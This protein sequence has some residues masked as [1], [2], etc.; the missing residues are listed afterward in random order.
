M[1]RSDGW[2]AGK[3]RAQRGR[4]RRARTAIGALALLLL[5]GAGAEAATRS[6][7]LRWSPS[8][9]SEVAGYRVY[10]RTLSGTW[11]TPQDVGLPAP[12]SD[13]TL[14]ATVSG[15]DT[16]VSYAFAVAAYGTSGVQGSLSNEL[17]L[18]AEPA[19]TTTTVAPSPS[20]TTTTQPPATT[21]TVVQQTTTTSSTSTSTTLPPSSGLVAAYAFSEGAGTTAADVSGHGNHGTVSGAAWAAGRMGAALAFD[22]VDDAVI[23]PDRASLDLTA[24]LTLEAWISPSVLSGWRV[25]VDKTTTGLPSNYYLGLYG[26]EVAFGFYAGGAWR[27]HVTS[28]VDLPANAWTH[29]AATFDDAADRVRIYVNGVLRLSA[30]ELGRPV[31]NAEQLRIGIGFANEAFAGRIDEVRVYDRA[32]T[33]SQIQADMNAAADA[34]SLASAALLPE[35]VC[36]SG[37]P[38]RGAKLLLK[39]TRLVARAAFDSLAPFDPSTA[40]M[41]LELADRDGTVLLREELPAARFRAG[42]GG[43]VFKHAGEPDALASGTERLL[44]RLRGE[45]LQIR[46]RA[47]NL[48]LARVVE[49]PGLS[50]SFRTGG[51]CSTTATLACTGGRRV[52]SCSPGPGV[53]R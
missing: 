51:W 29:V 7:R 37:E 38:R 31:A 45:R 16:A 48:D 1:G 42:A 18:A 49:E 12:A 3:R 43:R 15:L 22:G 20:T 30:V 34:T 21:T 35:D 25:I 17:A 19:T 41:T 8:P 11:G 14:S 2:D 24:A 4:G 47:R 5:A 33:A 40:G 52:R 46:L 50:L 39:G 27:D 23:V 6:A 9:S 10:T 36:L 26:D 32:L 53:Y 44:L 28:G 13:G